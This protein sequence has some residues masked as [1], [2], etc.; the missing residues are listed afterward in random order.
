M[1]LRQMQRDDLEEVLS[2]LVAAFQDTPFHQYIAPDKAERLLFLDASY[3]HRIVHALGV[4]DIDLVL[5][6]GKIIGFSSWTPPV[7]PEAAPP[8]GPTMDDV[9]AICSAELRE[10]FAAF[11]TLLASV[12]DRVIQQ[13]F[14]GLGPCAVLPAAQ[15]RGVGSVLLREKLKKIEAAQLPC[16]LATQDKGNVS[17]YEHFGFQLTRADTIAKMVPHYTMIKSA[18]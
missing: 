11:I 17:L 12:R 3:R 4:N 18:R 16:F 6:G 2:L 10:R 15:G 9:L 5:E 14:W 8:S 1:E 13:P 7:L